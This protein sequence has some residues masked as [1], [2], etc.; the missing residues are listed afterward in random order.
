MSP[1]PD[2]KKLNVGVAE[3]TSVLLIGLASGTVGLIHNAVAGSVSHRVM[4]AGVPGALSSA[5][6]VI[7]PAAPTLTVATVNALLPVALGSST[8]PSLVG[9][10]ASA[11][12]SGT[13]ELLA[14]K[15]NV[16]TPVIDPAAAAFAH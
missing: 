5:V 7:S 6:A 3:L 1:D 16:F 4:V 11:M 12:T 8:V 9:V 15:V 10:A 2:T 14:A 13:G